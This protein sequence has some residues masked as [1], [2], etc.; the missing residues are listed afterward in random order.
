MKVLGWF[1]DRVDLHRAVSLS[2]IVTVT[3]FAHVWA[4]RVGA[5]RRASELMR[6]SRTHPALLAHAEYRNPRR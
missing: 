6:E 5:E 3:V 2:A 1:F 4:A